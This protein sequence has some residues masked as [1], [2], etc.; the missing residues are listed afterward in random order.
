MKEKR[1]R[2]PGHR[3]RPR[4]EEDEDGGIDAGSASASASTSTWVSVARLRRLW[5]K[6]LGG[7]SRSRRNQDG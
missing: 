1:Q 4:R 5:A 2:R 7:E 6:F 3:A